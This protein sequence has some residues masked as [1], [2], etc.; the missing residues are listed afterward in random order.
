MAANVMALCRQFTDK[1]YAVEKGAA[2]HDI[3]GPMNPM[4]PEVRFIEQWVDKAAYEVRPLHPSQCPD[5]RA[6]RAGE[7]PPLVPEGAPAVAVPPSHSRPPPTLLP[8]HTHTHHMC[9]S[10]SSSPS[11]PPHTTPQEHKKSQ[12]VKEFVAALAKYG[13]SAE[14]TTVEEYA[15]EDGQKYGQSHRNAGRRI[16]SQAVFGIVVNMAVKTPEIAQAQM[17]I[18]R[19]HLERQLSTE[20]CAAPRRAELGH[21]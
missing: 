5:G 4:A 19:G 3:L 12:L 1:Y 15:F 2:R 21:S 20:P 10:C 11:P 13:A 18:L 16:G 8:P 7:S 17:K 9:L 14:E 6:L